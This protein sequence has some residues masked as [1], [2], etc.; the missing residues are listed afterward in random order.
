MSPVAAVS[1]KGADLD[2][3]AAGF[4]SNGPAL[5]FGNISDERGAALDADSGAWWLLGCGTAATALELVEAHLDSASALETPY[6]P[7]ISCA[8]D[9]VPDHVEVL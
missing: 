5:Q 7:V 4:D 1:T 3:E 2:K 9:Y 6:K 8:A